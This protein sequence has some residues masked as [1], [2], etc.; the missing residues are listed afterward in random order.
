MSLKFLKINDFTK[1]LFAFFLVGIVVFYAL[2]S[3]RGLQQQEDAFWTVYVEPYDSDASEEDQ[4]LEGVQCPIPMKD[5]VKNYTGTQCVFS[6]IEMLGRWAE[7]PKLINPPITS[8]DGCRSFSGPSHAGGKLKELNV[9]FEQESGNREAALKLI[10]KAMEEGRGCLFSVPGH[11]MVLI[12]Y[13]EVANVVKWVDNSDRTL[14]VQTMTIERFNQ[15]WGGWVLVVYA[16]N[17][18]ISQKLSKFIIIDHTNGGKYPKD[19][20][21]TPNPQ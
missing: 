12:H 13:D 9:R 10:K 6:S 18:I 15:R 7:E 4:D 3:L 1:Q 11:A 17:D 20:I 16:D 5:R 19:Y 14:K 2:D 8:R 21:P